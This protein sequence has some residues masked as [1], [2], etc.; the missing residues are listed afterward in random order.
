[1]LC[2]DA[3]PTTEPFCPSG[4]A[5]ASEADALAGAGLDAVVVA[6]SDGAHR[7]VVETALAAGAAVLCEKPLALTME[8]A[9]AM[10]AAAD[11]VGRPLLAA[12]TLRFEPRYRRI[13]EAV[14]RGELGDVVQLA[15][16][17]ATWA[18][19]GR[20]YGA[21]TRLE[22][23]LG[24]HDLDLMRWYAGEIDRVHAEAVPGR[25]S[26]SPTD[27]VSATIRF[28][29]GA[30]GLLELSWALPEETGIAWDTYLHC[31][32]TRR[33]VYTEVRGTDDARLGLAG[34]AFPDLTYVF[35]IEGVP[36]GVVR[37][38]DEHFL[39]AVREPQSW[40]G[41]SASD[42]RRAVEVA[43]ALIDSASSGRVVSLA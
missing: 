16:R 23:C 41:A 17:R 27:A 13:R 24:V 31:I 33:S 34:D 1:M 32:G 22:L 36:G 6:C 37:V 26:H 29:S 2:V 7:V 39:R 12:H 21:Q 8:D 30:I 18:P 5:F 25:V 11:A 3:D 40:P 15:A 14:A 20:I 42:A 43:L 19:E 35:E 9:D 10:L 38:Q 28:R 4:A